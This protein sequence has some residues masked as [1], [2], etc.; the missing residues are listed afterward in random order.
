MK[1]RKPIIKWLV[2]M[3]AFFL[4]TAGL[5]QGAE[6]CKGKCCQESLEPAGRD[7]EVPELSLN[8]RT[9]LDAFLPS[10]H[11]PDPLDVQRAAV[12]EGET[13]Q[14]ES[15]PSCCHMGKARASV[16]AL[17]V[18]GHFGGTDRFPHNDM[19]LSIQPQDFLNEQGARLD[20]AEWVLHPRAAPVPL[21]LKNTS[22]I[23]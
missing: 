3:L 8:P 18:Q 11:M 10:C 9:P 14:D 19:V 1:F 13:C 20:V 22:F 15:T 17:A 5:A 6:R 4:A 21:Y 7:P 12:T 23:C 2:W 16:Q